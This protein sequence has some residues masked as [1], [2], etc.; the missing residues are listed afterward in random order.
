MPCP[1][2]ECRGEGCESAV[3]LADEEFLFRFTMN[4]ASQ[5]KPRVMRA[6]YFSASAPIFAHWSSCALVPP[7]IPI[8]P[9]I[10]PSITIG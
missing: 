2:G 7:D 1:Q 10:F 6:I 8:A 9:T 4:R 3:L 5:T